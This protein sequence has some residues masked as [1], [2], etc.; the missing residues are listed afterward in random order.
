MSTRETRTSLRTWFERIHCSVATTKK[1]TPTKAYAEFLEN[2]VADK[3]TRVVEPARVSF[4]NK[5]FR[6]FKQ[7]K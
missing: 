1:G 3:F 7:N 5:F 2:S 4:K 6:F